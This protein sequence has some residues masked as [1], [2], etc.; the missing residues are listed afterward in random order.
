MCLPVWREWKLNKDRFASVNLVNFRLHVPSRL[1]GIE[2]NLAQLSDCEGHLERVYMCLPVW[3]EWKH[4][5]WKS[6]AEQSTT[7]LHVPSRLEGIETMG[8]L[9]SLFRRANRLHVP[10]R[11]EGIETR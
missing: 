5:G 10:S 9:L 11:L 6:V 4:M 2:T 8:R 7:C 1:E 3:R